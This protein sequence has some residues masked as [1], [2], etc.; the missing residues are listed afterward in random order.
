VGVADD[1]DI[2]LVTNTLIE[3]A[4][5]VEN[6]LTDPPP[7]VQFLSFGD[8]AL[9]FRLLV[10]TRMPRRHVEIRSDINYRIARLFRERSIKIPYPTRELRLKGFKLPRELEPSLLSDSEL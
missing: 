2:Q 10:W 8:Y 6:V 4:K 9:E 7:S 1:S 5:D 3:A